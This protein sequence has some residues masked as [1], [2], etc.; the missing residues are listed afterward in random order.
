MH[1][2][3]MHA[4]NDDHEDILLRTIVNCMCWERNKV[5][6]LQHMKLNCTC[7]GGAGV[8]GHFL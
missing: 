3:M 2:S 8:G 5:R 6:V 4:I 7:P 1:A